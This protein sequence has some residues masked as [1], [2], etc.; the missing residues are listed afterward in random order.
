MN[1]VT[2]G[3][4]HGPSHRGVEIGVAVVT[5]LFGILIMVGSWQV[6]IDWGVEG[7]K[8][9]FFPFYVGLI[10]LGCSIINLAQ[11]KHTEGM[12]ADWGQLRSV[13][14]VVIPTAIYVTVLPSTIHIPFTAVSFS[15]LGLYVASILLIAGFMKWLGRYSWAL[16]L[17]VA[18]SFPA[19]TYVIFEKWFLIPLPKGPFENLL[20]L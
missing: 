9:G 6:G 3:A 20:G 4:G 16:T 15:G 17:A 18:F 12:F 13:K 5:G 11:V 2:E 8:S 14:S 7:P 10:V 1:E 19:A